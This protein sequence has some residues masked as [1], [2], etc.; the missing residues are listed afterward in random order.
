[1]KNVVLGTNIKGWDGYKDRL[2]DPLGIDLFYEPRLPYKDNSVDNIYITDLF[3]RLYDS[4][5]IAILQECY[6][7]LKRR[8]IL[9]IS[10]LNSVF[11]QHA[12]NRGDREAFYDLADNGGIKADYDVKKA[13]ID[14]LFFLTFGSQISDL[15]GGVFSATYSDMVSQQEKTATEFSEVISD[16]GYEAAMTE[17][18]RQNVDLDKH[19][20]NPMYINWISLV[21]MHDF[22]LKRVNPDKG[23]GFGIVYISAYGQSSCP[24]MRNLNLFDNTYPQ[25]SLFIEAIR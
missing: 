18:L 16:L 3:E 15:F 14:Q 20:E 24:M 5:I 7:V 6:R 25:G 17:A 1:M 8:G 12:H 11:Y 19:K 10:A 13:D 2:N 23:R 21:K 22:L 9:R 4:S